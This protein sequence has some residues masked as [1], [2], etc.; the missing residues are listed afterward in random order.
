MKLKKVCCLRRAKRVKPWRCR[1]SPLIGRQRAETEP[2]GGSKRE[3]RRRKRGE[4]EQQATTGSGTELRPFLRGSV[5]NGSRSGIKVG[6]E[7][8]RRGE[9]DTR[10]VGTERERE[11]ERE[12]GERGEKDRRTE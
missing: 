2:I 8:W 3:R 9:D 4:G 7:D 6:A 12:R 11:R 5:G 1:G 10:E